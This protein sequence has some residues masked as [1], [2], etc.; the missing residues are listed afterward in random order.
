MRLT[1]ISFYFINPGLRYLSTYLRNHG[2]DVE[3]VFL[4][5]KNMHDTN[6]KFP[7]RALEDLANICKNSDIVGFSVL[8]NDFFRAS[9]VTKY[10]KKRIKGQI[11]WGG[12]HPSIDP[13]S[14]PREVD[15]IYVGEG[16]VGFL[17]LVNRIRDGGSILDIENIYFW[18]GDTIH[19]NNLRPLMR[20]ADL[21][22]VQ[23]FELDKHF[24]LENGKIVNV[25]YELVRKNSTYDFEND[26]IIYFAAFSRGC[27]HG[28]T[29]CCNNKLNKLYDFER[30]ILRAKT[31]EQMIAELKYVLNKFE[32][33]KFIYINDDNFFANNMSILRKFA[34]L[35]AKEIRLPFK[36]SGSPVYVTEQK[37][38]TLKDAG[39]RE[40]HIGIQSG[41]DRTNKGI[42]KRYI[43][44]KDVLKAANL[45][46]KHKL[47]ARFDFIFDNP[48]ET[49]EDELASARLILRLP[50]PYILQM[51]SLT[52]YPGTELYERAKSDGTL[53]DE[54]SQVFGKAVGGE[55]CLYNTTYLKLICL[56]LSR[57][58]YKVGKFLL[59]RPMVFI[60]HRKF[61]RGLYKS[62]CI[63]LYFF[64]MR[65]NISV[66]SFYKKRCLAQ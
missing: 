64:K 10:L 30:A 52:F 54:L 60:F 62:I 23:D 44:I 46:H 20:A 45:I 51:H 32:F 41:S 26:D 28:C 21:G 31:P 40:I 35:Y 61:L 65:F 49:T 59:S 2:H 14:C 34:Q 19:G 3:L 42:Y 12:I 8:T 56:L 13:K 9:E 4:P 57:L 17:E 15:Y 58:P 16:E 5:P 36:T 33:M 43:P 37:I 39:L 48:Y 55:S 38:L 25:T 22:H 7:Q 1:L 66:K 63:A 29:Y 24:I 11:V 47:R 27:V 53:F 6:E 18:Q 50:K